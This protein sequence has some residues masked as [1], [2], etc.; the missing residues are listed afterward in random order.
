MAKMKRLLSRAATAFS[1]AMLLLL[2]CGYVARIG[3]DVYRGWPRS[4]RGY[5]HLELTLEEGRVKFWS[6]HGTV[7][8]LTPLQN[9]KAHATFRWRPVRLARPGRALWDF[10]AHALPATKST[11]AAYIV[12]FPIWC[13]ALPWLIAPTM[14]MSKRYKRWKSRRVLT[15]C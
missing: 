7:D 8:P 11:P 3:F 14:W 12:A 5:Q 1:L 4:M 6:D 13:A 10:D 15:Y 9:F 2:A